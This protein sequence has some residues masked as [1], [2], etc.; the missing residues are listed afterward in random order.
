MITTQGPC[1]HANLKCQ[2]PKHKLVLAGTKKLMIMSKGQI[3][4]MLL[5]FLKVLN[6]Y[7]LYLK[8]IYYNKAYSLG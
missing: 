1:H 4:L 3:S 5:F 8:I 6:M 7:V 2:E